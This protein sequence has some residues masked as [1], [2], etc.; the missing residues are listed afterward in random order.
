MKRFIIIL[1]AIC[2]VWIVHSCSTWKSMSELN[3][4]PRN[5]E[6]HDK[7]YQEQITRAQEYLLT[8]P[9]K[10]NVPSFSIAVGLK[11]KIIWSEAVGYQDMENK[12][13]ANPNSIYRIGSTSK[14]VTSTLVAKLFDNGQ[15]NLE[16]VITD[17]I[18]NYPLK[19]W[20]F[21][22]RQLLSHSA[23]VPDYNDLKLGG[24]YKTLCNCKN[25]KSVT[26]SLNIFNKVRLQYEPNTNYQYTSLDFVLLSAYL[27]TI[28][29]MDFLSLLNSEIINP[30]QM[31][32]TFGDNSIYE[33]GSIARFYKTKGSNYKKWPAFGI[34]NKKIDL[35]YKWAGGGL[36]STPTDLVKMGNAILTDS[37]FI[38]KKTMSVFF[39]QQELENGEVNPQRYAL[40]WRSYY[41]YEDDA[42][43]KKVW[44]VHHGG[45]SKGAMNFLLLFPEYDLVINASINTRTDD[46]S[47][48]WKEVT[49]L[50]SF[51]LNHEIESTTAK[52]VHK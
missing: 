40:G 51:F 34:F 3:N 41:E 30:L 26:E 46:F 21:T 5:T 38:S 14:A 43:T 48:F 28:T 12:I 31:E 49:T 45:I 2:L 1:L 16:K 15:I 47:I 42:F 32:N 37:T 22:P 6:I 52:S 17:E 8:I 19:K 33:K 4:L 44:M 18:E 10:I 36:L 20:G 24:L 13:E 35:S 27:E 25:Y 7:A 11:G 50:S 39:K 23:G 29:D 9:K